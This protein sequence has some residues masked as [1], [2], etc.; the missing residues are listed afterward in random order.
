MVVK[1]GVSDVLRY[2]KRLP[3]VCCDQPA[4]EW[5]LC[6]Q[7]ELARGKAVERCQL[8]NLS[9]LVP[10]PLTQGLARFIIDLHQILIDS[11]LI[12]TEQSANSAV[13]GAAMNDARGMQAREP[14]KESKNF[15]RSDESSLSGPQSEGIGSDES[16]GPHSEGMASDTDV[17]D[18]T[19][20]QPSPSLAATCEQSALP[21]GLPLQNAMAATPS[22][23]DS[24][25]VDDRPISDCSITT[26]TAPSNAAVTSTS[27]S[28]AVSSYPIASNSLLGALVSSTT[29]Q[30]SATP[31][32]SRN[33]PIDSN[34]SATPGTSLPPLDK[35]NPFECVAHP[36]DCDETTGDLRSYHCVFF[37]KWGHCPFNSNPDRCPLQ[38][39]LAAHVW[40]Q[41]RLHSQTAQ[42]YAGSSSESTLSAATSTKTYAA[43]ASSNSQPSLLNSPEWARVM[44]HHSREINLAQERYEEDRWQ[45]RQRLKRQQK[46]RSARK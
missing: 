37:C 41:Q 22:T 10:S 25:T 26:P 12:V 28:A 27:S 3:E 8:V 45:R 14:D 2:L 9:K 32:A 38:H 35:P 17:A 19:S 44:E 24:P 16:I 4:L 42:S 5:L 39:D 20:R 13:T 21:L 29:T 6:Q 46:Q 30:P 36:Y 23:V 34:A 15:R 18:T 31:V 7:D 43:A 40:H 33:A 1:P 11:S